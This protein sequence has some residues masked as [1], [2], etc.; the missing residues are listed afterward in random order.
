ME[1][2]GCDMLDNAGQPSDSM[3]GNLVCALLGSERVDES[4]LHSVSLLQGKCRALI[5][6]IMRGSQVSPC[7]LIRVVCCLEVTESMNQSSIQPHSFKGSV[8]L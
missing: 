5:R 4:V 3:P 8:G 1:V 2:W 7:P 6:L